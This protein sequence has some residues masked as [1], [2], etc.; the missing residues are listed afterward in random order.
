[1]HAEFEQQRKKIEQN[2]ASYLCPNTKYPHIWEI[3]R[4]SVL[5]RGKRIRPIIMLEVAKI[6]GN[7]PDIILPSACSIEYIHTASLMLDDLP[8]MDN[9]KIRRHQPANHVMYGEANTILSA[10]GLILHALDII[11]ANAKQCQ[12]DAETLC[13]MMAFVYRHLGLAGMIFGQSLDIANTAKTLENI[14]IINQYKTTALF[15][16]AI[17][18]AGYLCHAESS[19]M[20]LLLDYIHNLGHAFQLA[21]DMQDSQNSAGKDTQQDYNKP[22]FYKIYGKTATLLEIKKYTEQAKAAISS[23]SNSQFLLWL[24]ENISSSIV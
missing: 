5:A 8:C 21:D 14:Q 22:T 24:A 7:N 9:A 11:Q 20:K 3:M 16:V 6:I 1:M 2:L 12:L 13:E 15:E 18:I 19:I 10:I 23:C 17:W 4:Y